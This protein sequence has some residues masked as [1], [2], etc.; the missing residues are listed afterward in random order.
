MGVIVPLINNI[1]E[2]KKA[3]AAAKYPPVGIRG[4]AFCRANEY[5][6]EF[7]QYVKNANKQISVIVMIETKEAVKNIEEIISVDGVDGVFVG[8]YDLSGSYGIP[9]QTDS[10]R[11][12]EAMN[13]IAKACKKNN[14]SYGIHLVNPNPD[15]IKNVIQDGCN[16]IALGMDTIFVENSYIEVINNLNSAIDNRE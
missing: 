14:K 4:F 1:D 8:P 5:G 6:K 12:R 3:V 2:A 10:S 7:D 11:I 16:F 13:I 9:G 15:N